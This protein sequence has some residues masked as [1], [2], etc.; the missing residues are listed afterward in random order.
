ML[1]IY[2]HECHDFN[3]KQR[4]AMTEKVVFRKHPERITFGGS[5]LCEMIT[6]TIL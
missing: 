1:D 2:T 6:K 5:Y 4:K 3:N